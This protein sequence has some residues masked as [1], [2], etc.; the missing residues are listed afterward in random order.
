MKYLKE[1]NSYKPK[2]ERRLPGNGGRRE[3]P[4]LMGMKL[5]FCKMKGVLEVS[6][7]PGWRSLMPLGCTLKW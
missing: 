7:I 3:N 5:Q 6:Q 4:C 2:V 1:S